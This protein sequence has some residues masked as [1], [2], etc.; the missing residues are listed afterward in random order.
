M[1]GKD[2]PA[3]ARVSASR[4]SLDFYLRADQTEELLRHI[5]DLTEFMGKKQEEDELDAALGR[6][7]EA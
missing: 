6:E 1:L 2:Y 4:A 7:K 5:D 3:P